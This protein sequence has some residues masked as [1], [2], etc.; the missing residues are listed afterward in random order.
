MVDAETDAIV[1]DVVI[2]DAGSPTSGSTS[3]ASGGT[4]NFVDA[5]FVG[6]N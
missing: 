2:G 1:S 4:L 3:G 6:G 5:L